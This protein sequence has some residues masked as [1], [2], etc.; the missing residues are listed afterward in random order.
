LE[1]FRKTGR[2]DYDWVM[3]ITEELTLR[4]LTKLEADTPELLPPE[5]RV[6]GFPYL[7]PEWCWIVEK[8][9]LPI[10]LIVT[11]MV[12]GI[13]FFWRV[14]ATAS[15]KKALYWFLACMPQIIENAKTMGCLGYGTFLSDDKPQEV[16][17]ARILSRLDAK[18]IP[19]VGSLAIKFF[20]VDNA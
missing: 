18:V 13:L 11:S 3:R 7:L 16:K 10:A 6:Y 14:L 4:P 20:G 5:L 8:N 9:G 12:H 17:F 15:A 2:E 1:G 19:W